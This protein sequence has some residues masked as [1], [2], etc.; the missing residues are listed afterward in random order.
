MSWISLF[1]HLLCFEV[2]IQIS[3]G[4]LA[5]VRFVQKQFHFD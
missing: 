3:S 4:K 1:H 5:L 2:N